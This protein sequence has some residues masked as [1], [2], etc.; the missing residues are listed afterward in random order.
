V[1]IY[2]LIQSIM[3]DGNDVEVMFRMGFYKN[4]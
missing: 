3:K 1:K 4:N 2:K